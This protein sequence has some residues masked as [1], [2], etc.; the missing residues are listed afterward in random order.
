[1]KQQQQTTATGTTTATIE[2]KRN[3]RLMVLQ[4]IQLDYNNKIT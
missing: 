4:P 2:M 1:M 3:E